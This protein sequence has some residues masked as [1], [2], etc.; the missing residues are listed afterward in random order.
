MPL[1]TP[2]A[3]TRS[4]VDR[5]IQTGSAIRDEVNAQHPDNPPV[6]HILAA[7]GGQ[8]ISGDAVGPNYTPSAD[9]DE[10][11]LAEVAM[12]LSPGEEREV[13][14]LEIAGRWREA[15]GTIPDATE[16]TFDSAGFSVGSE[17]DIQ[18]EGHD[19]GELSAVAQLIKQRLVEY[20]GVLDVADSFRAGKQE[21]Q[22]DILP[23]GETL[24]LT[25]GDLARQMR[26][27]FFGEEVQRIQRGRDD[28]RVMLRYTEAERSSLGTLQNMR[29]R[30]RD[31]SQ[32]PFVSIA[33]AQLG[34]G[35]SAIKR[36]DGRR[37]V[38]VTGDVDRTII[39]ANEVLARFGDGPIQEIM[40][41]YPRVAYSLEGSQREQSESAA[42]LVPLFILALFVIYS[43]LA[44]PLKS[45]AQPLIIMSVIPFA[46]VGAVWGHLLMKG[47]GLLNSMA[48]MSVMGFIAASGVVVNSSLVLVHGINARLQEGLSVRDAVIEAAVTRAR[49]IML[50]SLTT[51]AGLSPLLLNQSVQAAVLIP[52]A[53][54][55]A[56]GVIFSSLVT[57]LVVPSGYRI[58]RDLQVAGATSR[59]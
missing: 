8:P 42:S 45:Y 6:L 27:A 9:G 47:A 25:L 57:L 29:I 10:S 16:L 41:D 19:L 17:I 32:V 1:G 55:V 28:V 37:V 43:L 39:T 59:N 4:A 51:F 2:A 23:A 40:R 50:T 44:I 14:T 13:P 33:D 30:A 36:T 22:L 38:N 54:S 49:P 46:F 26:Q 12:Q 15:I 18:L 31:G 52:M 48:I 58:L 5:L 34:T 53:T 7:I 24:G 11:H 3:V 35:F 21:L 56:F 20:P